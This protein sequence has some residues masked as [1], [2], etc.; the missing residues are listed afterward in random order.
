MFGIPGDFGRGAEE[1]R[2]VAGCGG[3]VEGNGVVPGADRGVAVPVGGDHVELA[4]DAG[5]K[6]LFG[7][8]V[9][10]GA[11]ALTADL[12]DAVGGRGASR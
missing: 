11:D 4:D 10:D 9:D 3:G 6:Q 8:G 12:D 2:P 1:P 5:G 7:L